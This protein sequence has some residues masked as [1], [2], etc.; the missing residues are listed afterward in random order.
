MSYI[1]VYYLSTSNKQIK[2][3]NRAPPPHTIQ[4]SFFFFFFFLTFPLPHGTLEETFFSSGS[5]DIVI[6]V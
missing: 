1:T 6:W 3:L 2:A 4:K 5:T